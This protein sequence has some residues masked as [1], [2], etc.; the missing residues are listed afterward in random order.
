MVG[1]LLHN[2]T[3]Y[4]GGAGLGWDVAQDGMLPQW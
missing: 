4:Y 2:V 1:F 3:R